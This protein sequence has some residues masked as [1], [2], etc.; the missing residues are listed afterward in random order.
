MF[1]VA[2][3]AI[4]INDGFNRMLQHLIFY[5]PFKRNTILLRIALNLLVVFSQLFKFNLS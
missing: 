4:L 1:T 2:Y 3:N 5:R